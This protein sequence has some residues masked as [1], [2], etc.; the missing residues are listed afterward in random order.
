M[1]RYGAVCLILC[2]F[3]LPVPVHAEAPAVRA[4]APAPQAQEYKT[5]QAFLKALSLNDRFAIANM[6]SYPYPRPYPL[7]VIETPGQFVENWETFF[8]AGNIPVILTDS[9]AMI[10]D[11]GLLFQTSGI[12]VQ[13]HNIIP[14]VSS[15]GAK[16]FEAAKAK[17]E[18][19]VHMSVRGYTNV[20]KICET[21]EKRIR[22]Q[23]KGEE[24]Y[25][26]SWP[27]TASFADTPDMVLTGEGEFQGT[28]GG[29]IYTF[30]N[31]DDTYV[32]DVPYVCE[33]APCKD[34][35]TVSKSGQQ[36]SS[37]VCD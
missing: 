34:T 16:G 24:I 33:N 29:V 25:Y 19:S 15:T 12:W 22:V 6:V 32:L 28:M 8:D 37:E 2:A 26:F 35:L 13:G 5:A 27:K 31:A 10:G 4:I 9:Y 17:E 30:K 14:V 20:F 1:K 3:A 7:S 11:K 36:V 23:Q 18:K 21:T